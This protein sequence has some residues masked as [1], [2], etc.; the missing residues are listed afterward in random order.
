MKKIAVIAFVLLISCTTVKACI[1]ESHYTRIA[2]VTN[3]KNETVRVEDDRGHIWE[4]FG[5]GFKKDD[6]VKL[7]FFDNHTPTLTDDEITDAVIIK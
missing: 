6:E 5:T 2:K 3:V 7:T 4:F 1:Y